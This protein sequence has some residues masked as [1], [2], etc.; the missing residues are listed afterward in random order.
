MSFNNDFF[1]RDTVFVICKFLK[2]SDE[3]NFLSSCRRLKQFD[4]I[5]FEKQ[6]ISLPNLLEQT[7]FT[8]KI[9]F[10]NFLSYQRLR[11]SDSTSEKRDIS[12]QD[13]LGHDRSSFTA[14][15]INLYIEKEYAFL[16]Y[17][18]LFPNLK[19]IKW[20]KRSKEQV[21]WLPEGLIYLKMRQYEFHDTKAGLLTNLPDSILTL[22][23]Q[24]LIP[25]TIKKFPTRLKHLTIYNGSNLILKSLPETLTHLIISKEFNKP[26]DDLPKNLKLL[27]LGGYFDQTLALPSSLNELVLEDFDGSLDNLTASITHLTL[28]YFNGRLDHLP[29]SLKYLK[30]KYCCQNLDKLPNKLEF[31]ILDNMVREEIYYLP[32]RLGNLEIGS[33]NVSIDMLPESIRKLK[34]SDEFN[35]NIKKLP[36]NLE[37]LIFG[38]SFDKPL[39]TLPKKLHTLTFGNAFNQ[40]LPE[41]PDSL[42]AL[43]FKKNFNRKIKKYPKSL[44]FMRISKHYPFLNSIPK[45]VKLDLLKAF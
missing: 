25:L 14:K 39:P 16:M 42:N 3:L 45:N 24:S 18:D 20:R 31:L 32:A 12:T 37:H 21:N 9:I 13:L 10:S 11:Q 28:G 7:S 23:L 19:R 15:I 38:S 2:R 22:K 30:L 8:T 35:R 41:L 6:Y 26:L 40:P 33:S 43:Y 29:A 5:F 4:S 44:Q 27:H 34:L 1:I 17:K 36:Y